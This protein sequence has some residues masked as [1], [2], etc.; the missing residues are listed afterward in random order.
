MSR[1]KL[2]LLLWRWHR[3]LGLAAA[4]LVLL[5][6]A[7][8]ILLNHTSHLALMQKP[9]RSAWLLAL[10]GI[11]AP[12][13]SS[14]RLETDGAEQS[15]WLSHL[16]ERLYLD[17]QELAYCASRLRGTLTLDA[18]SVAACADEL[19]LFSAAGEV[20]ERIGA[21]YGV[22]Q[23][24]EGLGFCDGKPCLQTSEHYYLI[25]LEQLTWQ[26]YQPG[27]VALA[28]PHPLPPAIK[29]SLLDSYYGDAITWERV[30]LDLHNGNLLQLGPW[31][32]DLVALSLMVLAGTGVT[33]WYRGQRRRR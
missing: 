4:L 21:V 31:L 22:P 19:L 28:E 11:S 18:Y 33:M 17:Q 29:Q 1:S 26:P 20:I 9:V 30:L 3:R 7:T 15:Q 24:V 23:P 16:G 5:V 12:A 8:G 6:S 32:M 27:A 14:Y 10:Y 25:N 13:I 2:R